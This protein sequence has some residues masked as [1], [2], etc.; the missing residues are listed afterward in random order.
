MCTISYIKLKF[1]LF[2]DVKLINYY[3][4]AQMMRNQLA[5]CNI[6]RPTPN[7]L[8]IWKTY[9]SLLCQIKLSIQCKTNV[10]TNVFANN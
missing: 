10:I 2:N 9:F 6:P 7:Y 4:Y 1:H 3:Y 5:M 8:F